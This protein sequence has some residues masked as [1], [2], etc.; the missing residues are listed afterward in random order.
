[1]CL[2]LAAAHPILVLTRKTTWTDKSLMMRHATTA[3]RSAL[4]ALATALPIQANAH[5]KWFCS[6]ADVRASPLPLTNVLSSTF[7]RVAALFLVISALGYAADNLGRSLW[8]VIAH[9]S[10]RRRHLEDV[11]VRVTVGLFFFF[12]WH[13][14][15][16]VVWEK[17][18]TILT[19]ELVMVSQIIAMLQLVVAISMLWKRALFL[20]ATAIALLY[21]CG[22]WNYS[23]F[24]MTDYLFFPGLAIFFARDPREPP[25]TA[26]WR[27][28]LLTGS[29]ALSLMWTA[30]EKFLYPAWAAEVVALHPSTSFGFD[31][32]FVIV[33]A[34]FIEFSLAFHILIG[35]GLARLGSALFA[36]IFI[37]AIPDFGH[38]DAVGHLMILGILAAG[39]IRGVSALGYHVRPLRSTMLRDTAAIL[40]EPWL[41]AHIAIWSAISG[42]GFEVMRVCMRV[43]QLGKTR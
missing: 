24:H 35:T 22:I 9:P 4:V 17:G 5:V 42:G 39:M 38:L 23:V 12:L 34:A 14:H 10:I 28:T 37:S 30:I 19:P 33:V 41:T 2:N 29:L 8:P 21:V 43:F 7:L 15:V 36:L 6:I 31:I 20:G 25:G 11:I 40:T 32:P 26:P 18:G 1:M 13:G 27:T 3:L 16:V